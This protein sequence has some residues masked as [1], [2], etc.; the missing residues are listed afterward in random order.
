M[1]KKAPIKRFLTGVGEYFDI[2][3]DCKAILQMIVF[4]LDENGRCSETKKIKCY[5]NENVITSNGRLEL[6]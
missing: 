3:N 5:D 1:D 4:T 6:S 2:P